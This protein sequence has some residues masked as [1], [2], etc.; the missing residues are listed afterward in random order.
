MV[1]VDDD[2]N[3]LDGAE[4]EV[5][6]P[7]LTEWGAHAV[8]CNCSTGPATVLS[9]IERMREATPLPLAAMPNAGVP[10]V[11]EGRNIYLTS[12][13]YMAS[14]ARKFV[15]AGAQIVGGCCGTTPEHIR[16]MRSALRALQPRTRSVAFVVNV[17]SPQ[18]TPPPP[19]AER[20]K[21]GG[22]WRAANL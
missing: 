3:C 16:A 19:L 7:R 10:R 15:R 17:S 20:S 9:V 8:G 21:L 4:I 1:T 22:C 6:A 18:K 5:A 2:G 11:V 13:E 12:P 14:F